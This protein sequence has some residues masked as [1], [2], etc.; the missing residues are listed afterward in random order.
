[1]WI[2]SVEYQ[3]LNTGQ[4]IPPTQDFPYARFDTLYVHGTTL[5]GDRMCALLRT[6][7]A[8]AGGMW[9]THRAKGIYSWIQDP[10]DTTQ[11]PVFYLTYKYPAAKGE[12]YE[13]NHIKVDVKDTAEYIKVQAGNYNCYVYHSIA[14]ATGG[15]TY[16]NTVWIA[17]GTGMIQ[18]DGILRQK[19][20]NSML[21]RVK[22]MSFV[23]GSGAPLQ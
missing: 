18:N 7:S 22:L 4:I 17:P 23:K 2:F 16:E 15:G 12:I 1:M 20:Q 11:Q 13:S 3:D 9:Y 8:L 6:P 10:A 21:R 14:P 19:G 5:L